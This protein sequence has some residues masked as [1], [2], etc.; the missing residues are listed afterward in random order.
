[1]EHLPVAMDSCNR[2]N[3]LSNDLAPHH[4]VREK[5]CKAANSAD[6]IGPDQQAVP[7]PHA[8]FL[9]QPFLPENHQMWEVDLVLM[10]W[11]VGAVIEAEL[12]IVAFIDDLVM[13]G[14]GQ[15]RDGTIVLV[16]AVQQCVEGGTEIETAAAAVADFV[17]AQGFLVQLS[18]IDRID[19]VQA[20]HV[21]SCRKHSA[22]SRQQ[23]ILSCLAED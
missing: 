3:Q 13:I 5:C 6:Q 12:A 18:R 10:R 21:S 23:R 4:P 8:S 15:L 11:R 17:D 22:V 7:P 2:L 1:M 9:R 19:E 20:F 14:G 16:D